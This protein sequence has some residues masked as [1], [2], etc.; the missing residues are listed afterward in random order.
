MVRRHKINAYG[1]EAEK[2]MA[3]YLK[4]SFQDSKDAHIIS[5]LRL[6]MNRDFA[7]IDHLISHRFGFVT[8]LAGVLAV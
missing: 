5:D 2:Q 8:D 7:Q 6:E 3:F 4:R 1:H